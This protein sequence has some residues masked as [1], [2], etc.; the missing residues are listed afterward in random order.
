MYWGGVLIV[1]LLS[2]SQRV[3]IPVPILDRT[4]DVTLYLNLPENGLSVSNMSDGNVVSV[5][6]GTDLDSEYIPLI[7]DGSYR[8]GGWYLDAE[9]LRPVGEVAGNTVVYASWV[10]VWDGKDSDTASIASQYASGTIVIRN[11]AELKG[12]ADIVNGTAIESAVSDI[13]FSGKTIRI[14]NDIDLCDK[15]W[16]P[17]GLKKDYP[18]KGDVVG[19]DDRTTITGLRITGLYA[20]S[21]LPNTYLA[22]LFGRAENA[23]F[24]NLSVSGEISVDTV[25]YV[26][27]SVYSGTIA[28]YVTGGTVFKNC[29]SDV[30]AEARSRFTH[31]GGI[32][33]LVSG[34]GN[35][36]MD[37]ENIGDIT[38]DGTQ[39]AM[40]GGI[41]GRIY[42]GSCEILGCINRGNIESAGFSAIE[43][44]SSYAGGIIGSIEEVTTHIV[45]VTECDN[46][47]NV[48]A[49]DNP[50]AE[51]PA[52]TTAGGIVGLLNNLQG[53]STLFVSSSV[54]DGE[55]STRY[56]RYDSYV[57]TGGII[58]Y[59]AHRSTNGDSLT[60]VIGN[61]NNG[62]VR[63]ENVISDEVTIAGGITAI[64]DKPYA[65]QCE[66]KDNINSGELEAELI[67]YVAGASAAV[68][69]LEISG[70]STT[71][72]SQPE[73]GLTE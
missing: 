11:A 64:I 29:F 40:A 35:S 22:G 41:V 71:I 72:S 55:I 67:G 31:S 43:H 32:V 17:I 36:F 26:A 13:T 52:I 12:L 25:D 3:Y 47:G 53:A 4:Y 19:N 7:D 20:S 46:Y 10:S 24:S 15:E 61:T 58:G 63:A 2:C 57:Y 27:T 8:F 33:G 73:I 23:S 1:L 45:N 5:R 39:E 28:G 51:D 18:F 6:K 14:E 54:N 49:D 48:H 30:T 9:G 37:C 44:T 60:S 38:A 21:S 62:H 56:Y 70:N 42:P 34:T 59:I 66:I 69:P 65:S 16:T 50:D 68:R